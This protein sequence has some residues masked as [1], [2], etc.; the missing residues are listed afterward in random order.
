M[1]FY[2]FVDLV[3]S[4]IDEIQ[5]DGLTLLQSRGPRAVQFTDDSIAP[6]ELLPVTG[7]AICDNN[8]FWGITPIID[9]D[10]PDSA[11]VGATAN[12]GTNVNT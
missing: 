2:D 5:S 10:F 6:N 9:Q 8:S 7:I 12:Q 3:E 1:R 4:K 11:N